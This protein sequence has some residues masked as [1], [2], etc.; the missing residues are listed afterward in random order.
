MSTRPDGTDPFVPKGAMAFFAVMIAFYV[1]FWFA[2]YALLVQ[3]G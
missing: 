3:R 1:T 2:I